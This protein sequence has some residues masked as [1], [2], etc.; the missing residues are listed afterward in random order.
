MEPTV[1]DMIDNVPQK[2]GRGKPLYRTVHEW[3]WALTDPDLRSTLL[4]L[5]HP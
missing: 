2:K 5:Q 4:L 1:F 3:R